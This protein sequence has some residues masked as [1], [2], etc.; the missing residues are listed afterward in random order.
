VGDPSL[1]LRLC[2]DSFPIVVVVV[3]VVVV[4]DDDVDLAES[5][6]F[7]RSTEAGP[8]I[9]QPNKTTILHSF[10][11]RTTRPGSNRASKLGRDALSY[12]RDQQFRSTGLPCEFLFSLFLTTKL[13]HSSATSICRFAGFSF[14]DCPDKIP[15]Q[16]LSNAVG[17]DVVLIAA[18]QRESCKFH[19]PFRIYAQP[20][21]MHQH[22]SE[23]SDAIKSHTRRSPS[24]G[25]PLR[26]RAS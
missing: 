15:Q 12:S 19:R 9:V 4:V 23:N 3:V 18:D 17:P 22:A 24:R 1:E 2:S 13:S 11:L 25:I 6:A 8:N 21:S 14:H 26:N 5:F 7:A 20:R 16:P 10:L